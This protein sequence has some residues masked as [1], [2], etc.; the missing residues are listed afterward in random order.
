MTN[1]PRRYLVKP[2]QGVIAPNATISL[3]VIIVDK[4][5]KELI[6]SYDR[7]GSFNSQQDKFMV[8]SCVVTEDFAYAFEFHER[9]RKEQQKKEEE[10][11]RKRKKKGGGG[12]D[13]N[14]VKVVNKIEET[15]A[16]EEEEERPQEDEEEEQDNKK[17][18][19]GDIA[20][21]FKKVFSGGNNNGGAGKKTASPTANGGRQPIVTKEQLANIFKKVFSTKS[22]DIPVETKRLVAIHILVEK[23]NK[24]S[25]ISPT[26]PKDNALAESLASKSKDE[27]TKE[28]LVMRKKYD[29]LV[30]YTKTLTAE[31]DALR[32]KLEHNRRK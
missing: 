32:R 10:E 20:G 23:N 31:R 25:S 29:E 21:F 28:L 7:L 11:R 16:T 12:D 9:E 8:Q 1:Q 26:N 17:E 2:S 15:S 3:S 22:T 13:G 18:N 4:Y 6:Q 24:S 27:L 14:K 19:D 30:D 5:K